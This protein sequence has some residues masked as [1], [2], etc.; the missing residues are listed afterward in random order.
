MGGMGPG[1]AE[2]VEPVTGVVIGV[3][4]GAGVEDVAGALAVV[5]MVDVEAGVVGAATGA[6]AGHRLGLDRRRR[7]RRHRKRRQF[8]RHVRHGQSEMTLMRGIMVPEPVAD[9]HRDHADQRDGSAG[10][11]AIGH[12]RGKAQLR[13]RRP[14]EPLGLEAAE[15]F[16]RI[17]P[18]QLRVGAHEA[19][20]IGR[21]GQGGEIA[22]LD[23]FEIGQA[24]AQCLGDI[25]ELPAQ[26]FADL[27]QPGSHLRRA[28]SGRGIT[29]IDRLIWQ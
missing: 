3:V 1:A 18:E 4:A 11:A 24:D 28:G 25:G 10:H 9:Q 12:R 14:A 21:S 23:R 19:G 20:L 26:P 13:F 8:G 27:A 17:E 5:G 6:G 15:N 16:L 29:L 2:G 22:A 7:L